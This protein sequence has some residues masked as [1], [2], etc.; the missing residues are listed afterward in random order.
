MSKQK[1][2]K[3][4]QKVVKERFG[5]VSSS[6]PPVPKQVVKTTKPPKKGN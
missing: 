2:I 5:I 4:E 6:P 3:P 1:T